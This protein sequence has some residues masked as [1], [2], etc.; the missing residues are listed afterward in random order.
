MYRNNS[1]AL[2][3]KELGM[4]TRTFG[5]KITLS[6]SMVLEMEKGNKQV[7]DRTLNDI[8]KT[9]NVNRDWF[10]TG[11]GLMFNDYLEELNISEEIKE[12]MQD[13]LSLDEEKQ[14]LF[15]NMLSA[16]LNKK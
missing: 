3:R 5:Q 13:Y 8:C 10:E 7:S 11:N 14:L 2:L 12:M 4:T 1:L 6:H 16:L 15:R 9:F